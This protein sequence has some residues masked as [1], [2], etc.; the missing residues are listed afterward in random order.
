[1]LKYYLVFCLIVA[2]LWANGQ[3]IK[4]KVFE[5]GTRIALT[6]IQVQNINNKQLAITDDNGKYAILAKVGDIL[7]FTGFSYQTDT[8]LVTDL[9]QREV[10]LLPKNHLL[11]EV[12]VNLMAGPSTFKFYDPQFHG[13]TMVYQRDNNGNYKGGIILRFWYW[14]K[15]EKERA[16][17]EKIVEDGKTRE[18]IANLF[19][20]ATIGKYVPLQ[21]DEMNS[22]I[23]LYTPDVKVYMSNDFNLANYLNDCYKKFL[24]LPADKK[25]LVKLGDQ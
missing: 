3:S 20:A 14:K 2:A 11:N 18:K 8:V 25:H 21:G 19:N 1:M 7:V 5:K 15:D 13:Q 12:N 9:H 6:D 4:G 17:R 24:K 10:F 23:E 16:R 22:F